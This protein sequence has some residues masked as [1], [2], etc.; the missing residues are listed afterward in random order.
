MQMMFTNLETK[1][2]GTHSRIRNTAMI[3]LD[4]NEIN[5]TV[6][7]LNKQKMN[8]VQNII[9]RDCPTT[10]EETRGEIA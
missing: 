2:P 3:C 6:Q 7:S 5:E 9:S 4:N 8:S 1:I 10:A